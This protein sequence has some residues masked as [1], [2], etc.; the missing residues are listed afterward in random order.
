MLE[1]NLLRDQWIVYE[2]NRLP[3]PLYAELS[4]RIFRVYFVVLVFCVL[5]KANYSKINRD[6]DETRMHM[7]KTE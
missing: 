3:N 7:K 6:E 5:C 1:L 4:L 2:R